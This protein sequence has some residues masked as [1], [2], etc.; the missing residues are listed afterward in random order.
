MATTVVSTDT[1]PPTTAGRQSGTS[2][3]DR[4]P[5]GARPLQYLALGLYLLFLGFPLLWLLS[6]S[7]ASPQDLVRLHPGLF[8]EQPT[9]DNFVTAFSEQALVRSIV[10]SLI[11]ALASA[12]LTVLVALP[13]S[14]AVVRLRSRMGK[15]ILAWVLVSQ[16]FPFILLV[17]PIF[18]LL[19][20]AQLV[21]TRP[22]L[23][24]IYVV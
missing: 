1:A 15:P 6:T 21:D 2:P 13:A 16:L 22:G 8:P 20:S 3:M 10:N 14:Y 4:L 18:L 9:L 19:R 17:I 23:V 5:R 7:F 24:L 12:V 11:V